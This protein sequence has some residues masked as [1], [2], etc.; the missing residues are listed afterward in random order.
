MKKTKILALFFA[1]V[2]FFTAAVSSA[3]SASEIADEISKWVKEEKTD[4]SL[5]GTSSADWYI[6]AFSRLGEEKDYGSYLAALTERISSDDTT[7][8]T[9][10]QRRT[11]AILAVGGDPENAGNKNTVALGTY[12]NENPGKQGLNGWIWALIALDGKDFEVPENAIFTREK[13][14]SEILSAELDGGGFAM[15]G[16]L[17]DPDVTAMAITALAPYF[18]REEVKDVID[19]ALDR[20]SKMQT[21]NGDFASYGVRNS[22]STAQVII[23]LCS[24][25]IDPETDSRFIKN[26]KTLIDG[27]S[28]YKTSSGG[29]SHSGGDKA[30]VLSTGQVLCAAAALSR[31]KNSERALYD[32]RPEHGSE[33]KNR[34]TTLT[35]EIAKGEKDVETLLKDFFSLPQ[36]ERRYVTNFSVLCNEANAK[37]IDVSEIEKNTVPYESD[38]KQETVKTVFTEDDIAAIPEEPTVSDKYV[39]SALLKKLAESENENKA[40]YEKKLTAAMEKILSAEAEISEINGSISDLSKNATLFDLEKVNSLIKRIEA[41]NAKDREEITDEN[42]LMTLKAQL[43]TQARSIAVTAI[44]SVALFFLVFRIVRRRRR[45]DE[46]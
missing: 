35:V 30:D 27:L 40:E 24:V 32:F 12:E 6:I 43:S 46:E 26:G 33:M 17:P 36:S 11:L 28:V 5:A 42:A 13:I 3:A 31:L 4:F 10:W 45:K 16:T 34:I 44:L 7:K 19:R 20:L 37:E 1:A 9:E 29:F 21:E 25:G 22:G 14:I 2:L 38:E 39:V 18:Y 23:A 15:T 8:A 41:L